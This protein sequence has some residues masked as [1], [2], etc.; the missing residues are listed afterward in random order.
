MNANI[1]NLEP[2]SLLAN[3]EQTLI[4]GSADFIKASGYP[5]LEKTCV[6]YNSYVR[7]SVLPFSSISIHSLYMGNV[8]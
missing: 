1:L 5:G 8:V 4:S 6:M 3:T 2:A 7:M